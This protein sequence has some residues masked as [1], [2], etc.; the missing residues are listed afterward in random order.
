MQVSLYD[1]VNH[2]SKNKI[3]TD[4][5]QNFVESGFKLRENTM[6]N[7]IYFNPTAAMDEFKI[8]LDNKLIYVTIPIKPK[9]YQYT[10]NFTSYY[11]ATEYISY[12]LKNY[13]D[14]SSDNSVNISVMQNNF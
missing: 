4:I 13:L 2:L 9:N 7:L 12:H 5:H 14:N 8:R 3:F 6:T 1:N 11:L 10:T